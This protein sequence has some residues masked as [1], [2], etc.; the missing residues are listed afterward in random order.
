MK[1]SISH[2]VFLSCAVSTGTMAFNANAATLPEPTDAF[3]YKLKESLVKV[4]VAT[5]SGGHGFGTGVAIT[6]DHVVTNCHV[7]ENSSGISVAK[8]GEEFAPVAV[9]TDWKHDVCILRFE[10]AN[11]KPVTMGEATSL[12]YEQPII[13]IS[14]PSDTPAPYVALSTIKALY[15]MDDSEVIRTEAAFAIG[16]SGSPIFD[17]EGKLVGI[18]TFKSPGQKAYFYNMSVKWVKDLLQTP[19]VKFSASHDL[20]FWDAPEEGRPFF[21]QIVLPFQNGRWQDVQ[22]VATNWTA[23]EPK[24]AEAWYYLGMAAQQL[25]DSAEASKDFQTALS[26]HANH[27]ASLQA[28]AVMAHQQGREAEVDKIRL[29]LKE[30]YPELENSLDEALKTS[31]K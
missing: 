17:Y 18:S 21:M 19:E 13:S 7:I 25:G 31:A 29:T 5:K 27:P 8:W 9:Q 3:I 2:A 12:T 10:W 23:K 11:L 6:K 24:S 28:L 15:A 16:A 14:M 4:S 1:I 20:P 26:L 30:V 22:K